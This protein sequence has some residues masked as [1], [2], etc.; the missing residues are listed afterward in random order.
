MSACRQC[1]SV[2]EPVVDDLCPDCTPEPA[3]T[4]AE[5]DVE[6]VADLRLVITRRHGPDG[7][8]IDRIEVRTP[9]GELR[10]DIGLPALL[11]DVA[12]AMLSVARGGGLRW[13]P[14]LYRA[15]RYVQR[16]MA[17]LDESRRAEA[18]RLQRAREAHAKAE[19][20][21]AAQAPEPTE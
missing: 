12:E 9:D 11:Q 13:R 5:S 15:A 7:G 14:E 10:L 19:A 4:R 16:E 20:E 6:T 1:G 18:G 21:R 3:T 17:E 8:T 2:D